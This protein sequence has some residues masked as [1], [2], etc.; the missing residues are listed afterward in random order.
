[1]AKTPF[2]PDDMLAA[3]R[4]MSGMY[5]SVVRDIQLESHLVFKYPVP[6][7]FALKRLEERVSV[8]LIDELAR[9]SC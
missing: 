1:L 6:M 3:L 7:Q 2:H 9:L 8:H 4:G 5:V